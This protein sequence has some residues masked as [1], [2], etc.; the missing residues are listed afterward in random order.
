VHEGILDYT[1]PNVIAIS[2]WSLGSE[3]QD[4]KILSL[5]LVASRIYE[6][7]LDGIEANNSGCQDALRK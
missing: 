5:R 1:G 3:P 6:G 4:L 7:G 2:L